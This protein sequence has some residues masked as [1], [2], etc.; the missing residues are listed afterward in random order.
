MDK[1]WFPASDERRGNRVVAV[2]D[3]FGGT[4]PVAGI[5]PAAA[6]ARVPVRPLRQDTGAYAGD[7]GVHGTAWD[8]RHPKHHVSRGGKHAPRGV[9]RP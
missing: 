6:P 7:H 8:E 5:G 3:P 1:E 4:S 9:T 2:T